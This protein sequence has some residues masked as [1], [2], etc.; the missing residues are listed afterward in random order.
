MA[1]QWPMLC[2][3][4]AAAACRSQYSHRMDVVDSTAHRWD[5]DRSCGHLSLSQAPPLACVSMTV[6][7]PTRPFLAS[8]AT[9]GHG[10]TA[11]VTR[12][13]ET[14]DSSHAACDTGF[15]YLKGSP[16][17][18]V[19]RFHHHSICCPVSKKRLKK[20]TRRSTRPSLT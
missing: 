4:N 10:L 15:G 19:A 12:A 14:K 3:L 18:K 2:V 20:H 16:N 7:S 1:R 13:D 6:R 17:I 5:C 11:T 9:A 8:L